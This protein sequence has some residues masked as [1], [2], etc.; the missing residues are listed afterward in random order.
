[1][2]CLVYLVSLV[3]LVGSP[4]PTNKSDQSS[5]A[6]FPPISLVSFSALYCLADLLT[7]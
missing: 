2:V 1:M 3:H 7:T 6:Q 5:F 4:D